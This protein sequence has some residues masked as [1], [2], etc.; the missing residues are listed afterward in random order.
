MYTHRALLVTHIRFRVLYGCNVL[1]QAIHFPLYYRLKFC[2]SLWVMGHPITSSVHNENNSWINS[3]HLISSHRASVRSLESYHP[4]DNTKPLSFLI[5]PA[6]QTLATFS[7]FFVAYLCDNL[8]RI[9]LFFFI[10]CHF[11][12]FLL[13]PLLCLLIHFYFA[14]TFVQN[15]TKVQLLPN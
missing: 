5:K 14:Y 10:Q 9:F 8:W 15:V 13:I 12:L 2:L 6:G 4:E 7:I 3:S 11:G 1:F